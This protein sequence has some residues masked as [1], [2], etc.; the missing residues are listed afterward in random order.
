MVVDALCF[1]QES[2]PFPRLR[3]R[4]GSPKEGSMRFMLCAFAVSE[5]H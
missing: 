4:A 2:T 1:V 5:L 3:S